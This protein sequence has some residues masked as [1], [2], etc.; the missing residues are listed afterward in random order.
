MIDSEGWDSFPF[1]LSGRDAFLY[2]RGTTDNKGP[3]LCALFA[4]IDIQ[5]QCKYS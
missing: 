1:E 3:V 4:A 2:G 5:K